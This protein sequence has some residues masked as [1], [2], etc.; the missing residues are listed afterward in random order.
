MISFIKGIIVDIDHDKVV[1]ET[2][3]IGYNVFVPTT[4]TSAVGRTGTEV[5]LFTYMSVKEDS[6]SLFGFGSKE[7]L[8]IFKKMITVSG[9]GPK[10]ALAILSTLTV[11]KLKLAILSDDAKAIAKSPGIGAKTASKL[12][13]ELKDK[14]HLGELYTADHN[15]FV[16]ISDESSDHSAKKDAVEALVAL[17]YS[18]SES[19]NAVGKVTTTEE[20][21]V[22]TII[23]LALKEM[24]R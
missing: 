16:N 21:D 3:Q 17:G 10:G 11:D 13:L 7:E 22:S 12:I 15:D 20:F 1:I 4:Y 23:R 5:K 18:P 9:I 6:I 8:D 19:L 2:N 14:I 24:M